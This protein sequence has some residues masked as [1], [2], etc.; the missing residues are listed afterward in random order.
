MLRPPRPPPDRQTNIRAATSIPHAL[1]QLLPNPPQNQPVL[2]SL[3]AFQRHGWKD[4]ACRP[5]PALPYSTHTHQAR[6][7][8][9]LK[10]AVHTLHPQHRAAP[11]EATQT[12]G[13]PGYAPDAACARPSPGIPD[14]MP[15]PCSACGPRESTRR[16]TEPCEAY[17]RR[18]CG[19][20]RCSAMLFRSAG[21]PGANLL[22]TRAGPNPTTGSQTVLT[23]LLLLLTGAALTAA[24][25]P[26]ARAAT[27]S[28]PSFHWI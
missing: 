26:A 28:I 19:A 6:A 3:H 9:P 7:S 12:C 4:R 13:P 20:L 17:S 1:T 27:R 24:S 16:R 25:T 22:L 14:T 21:Q 18:I 10:H 15:S 2:S 23:Y 11:R 8:P 5:R